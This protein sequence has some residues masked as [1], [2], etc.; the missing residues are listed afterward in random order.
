[1]QFQIK[2]IKL[3]PDPLVLET[4]RSELER[5][6]NI[7][8]QDQYNIKQMMAMADRLNDMGYGFITERIEQMKYSYDN[9]IATAE[10][11]VSLTNPLFVGDL[12]INGDKMNK[13]LIHKDDKKYTL[14]F[15]ELKRLTIKMEDL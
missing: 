1:M 2:L 7:K 15:D 14:E 3:Q 8:S 11:I 4:V 12:Y 9:P 10:T 6:Y 5:L 13:I